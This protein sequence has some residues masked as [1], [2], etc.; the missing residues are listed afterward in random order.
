[1]VDSSLYDALVAWLPNVR[2]KGR[3]VVEGRYPPNVSSL[4][5]V[6]R[7]LAPIPVEKE[8]LWSASVLRAHAARVR[9]FRAQAHAFEAKLLHEGFDSAWTVLEEIER[10]L[11][12]SLWLIEMR[13]AVLQLWKGLDAQKQFVNSIRALPGI[14]GIVEFLSFH[15]SARNEDKVNTSKYHDEIFASSHNWM[16]ASDFRKYILFRTVDIYTIDIPTISSILRHEATSSLIDY[17]ETFIHLATRAITDNPQSHL[18]SLFARALSLL[19][20]ET[21]DLRICK[22][23]C[24]LGERD[25][26]TTP[27]EFTGAE[28]ALLMGDY[29]LAYDKAVQALGS[30]P[31]DPATLIT[32]IKAG[33]D[34]AG[35]ELLSQTMKQPGAF[36]AYIIQLGSDLIGK[37]SGFEKALVDIRRIILSL[38]FSSIGPALDAFASE[39]ISTSPLAD[40]GRGLRAFVSSP[41]LTSRVIRFLPSASQGGY[42]ESVF[43]HFGG[44]IAAAFEIDRASLD[45]GVTSSQYSAAAALRKDI[46]R[47]ITSKRFAAALTL[48]QELQGTNSIRL[49]RIAVRYQ[50]YC[51]ME[52]GRT[53][54][55]VDLIANQATAD[56]G[57]V[58][59]LPITD[60][61]SRLSKEMLRAL[62]GKLGIPILFDIATRFM[63]ESYTSRRSYAYEDFLTSH[64]VERPS[65]LATRVNEFDKRLLVYYLRFVC[66]VE[67]MQSS[68]AFKSSREVETER[69]TICNLLLGLDPDNAAT[70]ETE[71]LQVA[72]KQAINRGL[73]QVEQSKISIDVEPIRRW[74]S[75]ELK[76]DYLRYQELRASQVA[77]VRSESPRSH[78][79]APQRSTEGGELPELPKDE[80]GDLLIQMTSRF[81]RACFTNPYHGLDCYLSM[82]VRHGALSGQLRG[83]LEEERII[84]QREVGSDEYK[85]NE[86]WMSRLSYASAQGAKNLDECLRE[87]SRGY[88]KLI[89]SFAGDYIQVYSSDRKLGLFEARLTS[90]MLVVL[91]LEV[92]SDT[93]FDSFVDICF[94]LFWQNVAACLEA[95]RSHIDTSVK[96]ETNKLFTTLLIDVESDASFEYI[97]DLNIAIRSGQTRAIQALE[98]VKDWFRPALDTPSRHFPF[99][100]LFEIGLEQVKRIHPDFDPIVS[101]KIGEMP[102]FVELNR[103]S[104][105]FFIILDNIRKHSGTNRPE[106]EVVADVQEKRLQV[107]IR[108]EVNAATRARAGDANVARIREMIAGGKFQTA[109]RSEGGTGLIKLQN[110][111]RQDRRIDDS[112]AFGFAD[113]GWFFVRI[114]LP[115]T[116]FEVFVPENL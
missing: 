61:I 106:V 111:V 73:R 84:T 94:T 57:L 70:Y 104:D 109:T 47:E 8:I 30:M 36:A 16:V 28:D 99:H 49:R 9:E 20:P 48:A 46:E 80:A 39:E 27:V 5:R 72:R 97:P 11:G 26:P 10:G 34:K 58:R 50:A 23:Q 105:M 102:E 78:Q 53:P 91:G 45:S 103:F 13:I 3:G 98:Q 52:L 33:A 56:T 71:L 31:A 88:D 95:V 15:I 40:A 76:E 69:L 107:V 42:L 65:D 54:E 92:R 112:L 59:M 83:P 89:D 68:I 62:A 110:I 108:N 21:N 66:I 90:L 63:S 18:A 116:E 35:A 2:Y 19:A 12:M 100:E 14:S 55:L 1:M 43:P 75:Q 44:S 79:D 114:E 4:K 115:V 25:W 38:R 101:S 93:V 113:D 81:L 41:Y 24:L 77:Q 22:L 74:A 64:G 7:V 32:A 86:Y 60:C 37:E 96:P 29:P 87:F 17:Y 67:V 82:R 85:S 51:L 6:H